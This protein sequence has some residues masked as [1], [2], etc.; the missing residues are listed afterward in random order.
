MIMIVDYGMGNLRSVEKGFERFGFDVKVTDNFAEFKHAD[1]L[2]VPG[3]GAFQDAM[4]GLK[5]RGLIEPIV[6][7]IQS[8]KPFLGIC[9]GLQLLFSLG[10][11]DGEH[12]GLGVIP[13]KVIR[14]DFSE[15]EKNAELKIPHMGW[16]QIK[17]KK[18]NIPILKD[19]PDN[20]YMYF[21][22]SYYVCPEDENVVAT[23]TEYG[24]CFTSMVWHKNIFATQFHPEKSQENGLTILKNFGNL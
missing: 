7:W 2:V 6:D 10:Y 16:N 11:E 13:G 15:N 20:A 22:H 12:K 18:E 14:F 8:G 17:C 23:E 5:Q 19:I 4:E 21:V 24:I 3:V 1:K 9:L